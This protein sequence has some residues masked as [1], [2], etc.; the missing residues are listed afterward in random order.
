MHVLITGINGY[1]AQYLL[2]YKPAHIS[3]SGTYHSRISPGKEASLNQIPLDLENTIQSQVENIKPEIVI[4]TAAISNLGI[5]EKNPDLAYRVNSAAT[6]ELAHWCNQI[7]ARL[8]YLST[9]IVFDG[10]N[11]PYAETDKPDPLNVYGKSKYQGELAVQAFANNTIVRLALVLGQGLAENKNFVDWIIERV[12]G[13]Q[14]VPLFFDE[15]RTPLCAIDVA[16]MLWQIVINNSRGTFH[17]CSSQSVD[18]FTLGKKICKYHDKNFS[19]IN[20]IAMKDVEIIRPRDVS[21]VNNNLNI[22]IPSVLS[23]IERLF[24][25]YE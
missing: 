18:R 6:K 24:L 12:T 21:M 5:C 3:V 22:K 14:P 7:N 8:L 1:I 9:D 15:I 4:H 25:E 19:Q 17:L 16:K 20:K 13:N 10:E 2:K 23:G 11:A